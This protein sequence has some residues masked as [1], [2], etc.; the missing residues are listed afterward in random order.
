M[1]GHLLKYSAP[2]TLLALAACATVA[3]KT[4]FA[5]PSSGAIVATFGQSQTGVKSEGLRYAVK[6]SDPIRAAA[7]GNIAFAGFWSPAGDMIVIDHG[8]GLHSLYWGVLS[9][10]VDAGDMVT[11]GQIIAHVT[12]LNDGQ[13]PLLSFEIRRNGVALDPARL[14]AGL[15]H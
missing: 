9:V 1:L 6:P 4:V 3:Q 10:G 8:D 7:D 5:A 14:L 12:A 11:G 15:Q 2:L 13:E